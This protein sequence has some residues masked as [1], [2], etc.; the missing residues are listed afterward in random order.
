MAVNESEYMATVVFHKS[1]PLTQVIYGNVKEVVEQGQYIFDTL[2]NAAIPAE[3]KIREIEEGSVPS[4]P[5]TI[6]E[7]APEAI[8]KQITRIA[9]SSKQ[10]ST[11]LT[12]G[13]MQYS[14]NY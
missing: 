10:L 11:C 7:N 2:W 13:G 12:A 8:I 5:A 1:K 6:I 3:K 4:E 9:E 14:H